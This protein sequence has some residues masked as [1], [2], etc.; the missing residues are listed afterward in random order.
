M[1]VRKTIG[2][3]IFDICNTLFMLFMILITLYPFYYVITCSLSD[4][5][6]LVGDKGAML[7]PKGFSLNAYGAVFK[8]PNILSGYKITLF[9]VVL[10]TAINVLMTAMGAFVVTRRNFPMS[11]I[12][13]KMMI[14]TMYFSG[15]MI[16]S[17]LL[18]NNFLGL[19]DSLWALI[20]PMAVSTYNLIIM[21]TNFEGIPQSLEESAEIDGANDIAIFFRIILPLSIPILAVMVLFYGVSHWNSWFQA[22]LY[23]SSRR[24]YPLQLI[25]R[26]ILIMNTMG[27]MLQGEGSGDKYTIGEGIRYATIIAATL[28]I[29]FVYP[30]IQKYFV[31]GIMIGA[32]K[33]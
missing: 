32:V 2:N 26:E 10:G 25:L 16:P 28:P 13:M 12:M 18:V 7:W 31:K 8:N 17:Y 3:R 19:N 6:F 20:L 9:V 11:K 23:I 1:I 33:G 14:F 15:G 30:F 27:D 4:S 24:K 29:L 21:K 22:L 5:N